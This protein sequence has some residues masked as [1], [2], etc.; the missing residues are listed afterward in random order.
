MKTN[1]NDPE[2]GEG[3]AYPDCEYAGKYFPENGDCRCIHPNTGNVYFCA[4]H[5]IVG[6]PVCPNP[7]NKGGAG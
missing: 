3:E 4:T 2:M 1:Y 7:S 5:H 6:Y